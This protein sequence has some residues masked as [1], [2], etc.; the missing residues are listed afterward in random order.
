LKSAAIIESIIASFIDSNKRFDYVVMRRLLLQVRKDIIVT[1][2]EKYGYIILIAKG[3][4]KYPEIESGY[5]KSWLNRATFLSPR[6]KNNSKY[7][8]NKIHLLTP[9]YP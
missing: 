4:F 6:Q 8:D 7:V 5:K 9:H 3:E 1:E 2:D